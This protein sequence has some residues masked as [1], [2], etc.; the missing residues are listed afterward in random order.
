MMSNDL[1]LLIASELYWWQHLAIM[2]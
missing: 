2:E 1:L